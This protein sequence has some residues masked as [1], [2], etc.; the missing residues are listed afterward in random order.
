MSEHPS[1][2]ELFERLQRR[3]QVTKLYL[4]GWT[5]EAIAEELDV[6]PGIVA[7]DVSHVREQWHKESERSPR[8]RHERELARIDAFEYEAWL[9]WE[10]S[11]QPV[12]KVQVVRDE[13]GAEKHTSTLLEKGGDP[14]YLGFILK[15]AVL[16]RTAAEKV[17]EAGDQAHPRRPWSE[18]HAEMG[19]LLPIV[20]KINAG[21][22]DLKAQGG[23]FPPG[24]DPAKDPARPIQD[25]PPNSPAADKVPC[26]PLP[27]RNAPSELGGET[28]TGR[29]DPTMAPRPS[30]PAGPA[31]EVRQSNPDR[32]WR[33]QLP[34]PATI[35]GPPDAP[36]GF[37][38]IGTP[39]RTPPEGPSGSNPQLPVT[40]EP[41]RPS[42]EE[43]G[44]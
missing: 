16:R 10:A 38:T 26:A 15:C 14:R 18:E 3:R 11:R 33:I 1:P 25:R 5:E 41:P 28:G 22:R 36:R 12:R 23:P 34:P 40:P 31:G 17:Q 8:E 4:R 30:E 13:N 20:E 24:S 7:R 37:P 2:Q 43:T 32:M 39:W 42:R 19:S 27:G 44:P 9:A 21:I 6:P 29:R 35:L